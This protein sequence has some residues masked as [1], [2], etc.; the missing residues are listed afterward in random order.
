[1][2]LWMTS[3]TALAET[4]A[5]DSSNVDV[6]WLMIV[7]GIGLAYLIAH[8]VVSRLQEKFLL[9][10]GIEYVLL[11]VMIGPE[12]T[13]VEDLRDLSGIAPLI[14]VAVGWV[15]L[16]FGMDADVKL[17][18]RD[19]SV[20]LGL[21]ESI[22]SG[23]IVT[24]A[25]KW[26]FTSDWV[27]DISESHAWL[28]AGVMGCAA[29]AGSTSAI[30]LMT[31]KYPVK[32]GLI[33]VL[34]RATNLGDLASVIVFGLLFCAFHQNES[35]ADYSMSTL[36]WGNLTIGIGV[37]I[38]L[39]YSFFLGDDES[40]N[41]RF[42]TFSGIIALASGAA[43]FLELSPLS[44]NLILGLVLVYTARQGREMGKALETSRRPIKL[45]LF[46]SA[47]A[48]WVPPDQILPA[49]IAVVGYIALRIVTKTLGAWLGSRFTSLRPDVAR[50]MMAQGDVA[51]AMAI[52]F[53]LVF[54]NPAVD[55][56]YTAILAS[57]VVHEFI[58]PRLLKGLLV[59]AGEIRREV[60]MGA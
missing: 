54:D 5:G 1:M 55:I 32:G 18:R 14:A 29:A 2:A 56:A 44:I 40:E 47:G 33:E 34:R 31:S 50:G 26:F 53:K 36:K 60:K 11:G 57:V 7:L 43:Y 22:T 10:T 15:G 45:I 27:A 25:A 49:I 13:Q 4:G 30:D 52:S 9:I 48:L 23:V 6:R 12:L 38:G 35:T 46:V 37:L 24:L 42:L 3:V 21:I 19:G 20:T 39:L 58:A 28:C 41:S 16:L 17:N 8:F 59:D 51:L